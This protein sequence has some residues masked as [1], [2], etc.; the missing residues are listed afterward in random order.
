VHTDVVPLTLA[1]D[2]DVTPP[3]VNHEECCT[4]LENGSADSTVLGAEGADNPTETTRHPY[5]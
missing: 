2:G 4:A 1:V 5:V 3:A